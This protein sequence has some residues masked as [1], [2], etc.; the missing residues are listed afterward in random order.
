MVATRNECG[1]RCDGKHAAF[2]RRFSM[3]QMSS[4]LMAVSVSDLVLSRAVRKVGRSLRP[5]S[6][7]TANKYSFKYRRSYAVDARSH[8]FRL[9]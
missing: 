7:P 5:N 2:S 8:R 4:P 1:E 6:R 9:V 3:R